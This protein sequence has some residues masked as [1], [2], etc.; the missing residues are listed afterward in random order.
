MIPCAPDRFARVNP[1][2]QRLRALRVWTL[3]RVEIIAI[4][5]DLTGY[6]LEPVKSLRVP[7]L[8]EARDSE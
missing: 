7:G 1:T 4:Q 5:P 8:C 6:K 3:V 2:L